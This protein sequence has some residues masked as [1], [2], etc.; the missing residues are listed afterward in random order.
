MNI[1]ITGAAGQLGRTLHDKIGDGYHYGDTVIY[2]DITTNVLPYMHILDI[3]DKDAVDEI[4]SSYN[5]DL[6]VNCAA[7]TNVERAEDEEYIA[8]SVNCIGA[9]NLAEALKRR[10]GRLIHISTDYV[11]DGQ[12][13]TP[14]KETMISIPLNSYGRTKLDGER[15]IEESGV[16]HVILRTSLLYSKYGNN[17]VKTIVDKLSRNESLTVVDDQIESPTYAP[18]LAEIII[19][20][21]K[22]NDV[23]GVLHCSNEG[24]CSCYDLA[25]A[26]KILTSSSSTVK[27]CT[28]EYINMRAKLPSYSVMSKANLML[29]TG[30][31][32][33]HWMESLKYFIDNDL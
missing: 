24:C 25:Y 6:A 14:Y 28:S 3:T 31:E 12:R 29:A 7:Y 20:V 16:R 19:H 13:S 33:P 23:S 10:D 4:I 1:L 15:A 30:K 8:Y 32:M 27:P 5:I 26:L 21:M 9:K 18:D 17:F 22:D 11:Y 2:A